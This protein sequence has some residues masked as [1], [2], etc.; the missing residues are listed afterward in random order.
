[1]ALI[2]G[3]RS[4]TYGQL[5]EL[6]GR[7]AGGL[8]IKGIGVGDHVGVLGDGQISYVV[9]L[10]AAHRVGAVACPMNPRHPVVAT[11]QQINSLQPGIVLA[12]STTAELA[13][14][15]IDAGSIDRDAVATVVGDPSPDLPS[16]PEAEPTEDV[17]V[18]RS[19]PAAVLHTSGI[20]GKPR[21]AVLTHDN[22]LVAQDRIIE[23]DRGLRSDDVVLSVLP[24]THVLGLNMCLLPSLRVGATVVLSSGRDPLA[25]LEVMGRHGVTHVI[26]VPPL[27]HAWAAAAAGDA[28]LKAG[29]ASVSFARS[30]ASPLHPSVAEEVTEVFGIELGQGYGLT[31]TA[32]TVCFEPSAR[33]HPGS[34]GRPLAGV[35]VKLI[36]E[37]VEVEPGDR[38]EI[39]IRTASIFEGYLGDPP[40]T[41]EV[42]LTGGWCRTGD[43]GIQ[44]DDGTIYLV[45]RS[46]DLINVSGFNVFPAEIEA[47]LNLHPAVVDAVV[48]GEPH[49]V[50]GEQIV[51]Y[52]TA[53]GP[54]DLTALADHCRRYLAR[55]KVPGSFHVVE[56]LPLTSVGKRV[57]SELR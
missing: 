55:Y 51:A 24:L 18:D 14:G 19:S 2:E 16:L 17:S 57:R 32:G 9:G 26:A 28:S 54:I 21:P 39:W 8:L 43:I 37:S 49:D 44:D 30:G 20:V 15:L 25:T 34:V 40:A 38:G 4:L 36:D 10:L 22:L 33:L 29:L 56:K 7:T 48:V 45:G 23:L 35:E 41:A 27:W 47:V 11:G 1:M 42:L 31:E 53:K 46:K 12:A 6:V 13:V 3:D 52:V 5:D 50:T